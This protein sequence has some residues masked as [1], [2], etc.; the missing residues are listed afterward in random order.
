MPKHK[1]AADCN[2]FKGFHCKQVLT[3]N[4]DKPFSKKT[5]LQL[6]SKN[7]LQFYS[8]SKTGKK[9]LICYTHTHKKK[10]RKK[11]SRE[12]GGKNVLR[13]RD[14]STDVQQHRDWIQRE[15]A[16]PMCGENV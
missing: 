6:S 16:D 7:V 2:G 12:R 1:T 13:F 14:S 9:S 10:K 15:Q 8:F 4:I 5:D 3:N 11:Q